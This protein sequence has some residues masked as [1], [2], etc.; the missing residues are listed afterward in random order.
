MTRCCGPVEATIENNIAA[1]RAIVNE[2][3]VGDCGKVGERYQDFIRIH[4]Q[5]PT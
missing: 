4:S 2:D 3:D 1:V 5:Y